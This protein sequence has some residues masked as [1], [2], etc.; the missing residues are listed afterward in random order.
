M[1]FSVDLKENK[2]VERNSIVISNILS[3]SF[4]CEKEIM[5]LSSV[6]GVLTVHHLLIQN[7]KMKEK[8]KMSADLEIGVNEKIKQVNILGNIDEEQESIICLFYYCEMQD[9]SNSQVLKIKE[10]LRDL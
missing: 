8:N 7:G 9:N 1:L 5:V 3:V 4:I 6:S 10:Y 2:I